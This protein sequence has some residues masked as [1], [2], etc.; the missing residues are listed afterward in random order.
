MVQQRLN[1]NLIIEGLLLT[2]YDTRL[3][4]SNQVVEEALKL[5]FKI[6]F[7]KQSFTEMSDWENLHHL[8]NNYNS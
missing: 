6:W 7:L 1:N 2:M 5:I 8:R 4:L 3:R